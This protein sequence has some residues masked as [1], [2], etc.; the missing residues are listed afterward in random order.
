MQTE[1]TSFWEWKQHFSDENTCLQAIIK[2]RWPEGFC[3]SNCD[4][5]SGWL[6]QTRHVFEFAYLSPTYIENSGQ[7]ISQY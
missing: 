2:Q 1:I 5:D 4:H 7:L 6:L 3:C